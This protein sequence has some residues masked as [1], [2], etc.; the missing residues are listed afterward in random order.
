[1]IFSPGCSEQQILTHKCCRENIREISVF[2]LVR[3][4]PFEF[5]K[6]CLPQILLGSFLKILSL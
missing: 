1:M 3:P 2:T 4:Y 5:L 6:G